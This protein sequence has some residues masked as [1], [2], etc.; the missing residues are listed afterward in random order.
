MDALFVLMVIAIVS[1]A[2]EVIR[3]HNSK[4]RSQLAGSSSIVDRD[5]ERFFAD[6]RAKL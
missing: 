5:S 4:P 3:R 6:L 2:L 1:V